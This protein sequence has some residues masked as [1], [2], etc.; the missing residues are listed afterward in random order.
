M[1]TPDETA[2]PPSP[3]TDIPVHSLFT[4][5][6][7]EEE[8]EG[9]DGEI[10]D[11]GEEGTSHSE[12]DA[13]AIAQEPTPEPE[14]LEGADGDTQSQSQSKERIVEDATV[15]VAAHTSSPI[16]SPDAVAPD[17]EMQAQA[18]SNQHA[19]MSFPAQY[20]DVS[21]SKDRVS[22]TNHAETGRRSRL[23]SRY[24]PTSHHH[25]CDPAASS[26]GRNNP[27]A[28]YTMFRLRSKMSTWQS[29]R[30]VDTCAFKVGQEGDPRSSLSR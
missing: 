28:R 5:C 19:S 15:G 25:F 3:P 11:D 26:K 13:H 1:P 20:L 17:G 24:Y 4:S 16:A 9:H 2:F 21:P 7:P 30:F 29:P 23:A 14:M 12:R 22:A 27:I 8:R 6:P 10:S 18:S